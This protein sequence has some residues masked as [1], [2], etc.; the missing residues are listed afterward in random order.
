MIRPC[1]NYT[2]T[3]GGTAVASTRP[4]AS[5]SSPAPA[6]C[7]SPT[8]AVAAATASTARPAIGPVPMPDGAGD[9]R[10]IMGQA[11]IPAGAVAAAFPHSID[12]LGR[13]AIP[14]AAASTTK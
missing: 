12:E 14:L 3:L 6:D 9:E 13:R 5:R 7:S 1:G 10:L 4:P 8:V 11:E 2:T